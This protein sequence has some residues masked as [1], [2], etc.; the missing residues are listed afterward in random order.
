MNHESIG[1]PVVFPKPFSHEQDTMQ[2]PSE[3]VMLLVLLKSFASP[4]PVA[5]PRFLRAQCDLLFKYS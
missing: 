2:G 1:F 4:R 3:N 5:K